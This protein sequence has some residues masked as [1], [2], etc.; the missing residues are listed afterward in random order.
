[1]R[2][3]V[4]TIKKD[5]Y[6]LETT[7]VETIHMLKEKLLKRIPGIAFDSLKLIWK[8]KVLDDDMSV[9]ELSL[10][11]NDILVL[12]IVKTI[13]DKFVDMGFDRSLV[14]SV[15]LQVPNSNFNQALDLLITSEPVEISHTKQPDQSVE[16]DS[17]SIDSEDISEESI[18]VESGVTVELL[19]SDINFTGIRRLYQE[20]PSILPFMMSMLNRFAPDIYEFSETYPSEFMGLMHEPVPILGGNQETIL[21]DADMIVVNKLAQLGYPIDDVIQAYIISGRNEPL[22]AFMLSVAR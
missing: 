1:M 7:P 10:K 4:R 14:D 2:L 8:G 5:E 16:N 21:S 9:D 11:D 13:A 12:H 6:I 20:D 22:A 3:R 19:R 17:T 18:E 15:L